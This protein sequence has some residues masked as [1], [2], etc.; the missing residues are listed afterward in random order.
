MVEIK[1]YL[2]DENADLSEINPYLHTIQ[3]IFNEYYEHH[4]PERQLYNFVMLYVVDGEMSLK[5]SGVKTALS[6]GDFILIPPKYLYK[7]YIAHGKTCKYYVLNFDLFYMRERTQWNRKELYLQ[8][9]RE[10]VETAPF[11]EAYFSEN[12]K[13]YFVLKKPIIIQRTNTIKVL[14]VLKNLLD[15]KAKFLFAKADFNDEIAVKAY[16]LNLLNAVFSTQEIGGQAD[17]YPFVSK[18]IEYVLEN[19]D[20]NFDVNEVIKSIGYSPS[21]FRTIFKREVGITPFAYVLQYRVKEAKELLSKGYQVKTVSAKVGFEDVFYFS[22]VFKKIVGQSP[23][24]Y[25]RQFVAVEE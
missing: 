4:V 18:F 19:Y 11:N 7:E 16:M 23:S 14:S 5:F 24:K 10:G 1:D 20:R 6:S 17:G 25:K 9:C 12:D 8:Y 2:F 15:I 22:K 13:N 21:Y 3:L